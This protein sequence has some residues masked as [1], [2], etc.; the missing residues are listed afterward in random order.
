MKF[1]GYKKFVLTSLL[2]I[3]L[4]SSIMPMSFGLQP[5]KTISSA[6]VINY[7]QRVD[8][9]VNMS[10]VIGINNL[11]TG[12]Q[13]DFEWKT[14]RD[15]SVMRQLAK[16]A[17]FNIVRIHSIRIE[18]CKSW[19]ESTKTGTFSWTD[20]DNLM[21]KIFEIGAEP[22]IDLGYA[23]S[24][25]LISLPS[26]MATNPLT[27]LPY[28]DSWAAYCREWVKHFK[29]V[30]LPVRF[31]EIVN[32]PWMYFG[33]NNYTRLGY[34][35]DLFNAAAKAMRAENTK[36]LLGFDGTNRKPVL[37]YW[38]ANGGADL[39]FI[40]FH[41]YDS[42]A[43]GRYTD[44][45]MFV[46]AETVYMETDPWYYGIKDAQLVYKNA[47]G[48]VIPVINSESN[49]NSAYETGTDP[50]IQQ[51]IGAVWTALVLRTAILK[52]LKYNIYYCFCSSASWERANKASGGVG[53]G[54][55]NSDNN[56]PW[57]PYYVQWM[58]GRSLSVGDSI[59]DAKSSSSEIKVLALIH[60][61]RLNI[62]LICKVEQPRSIFL[63][64]ITGRLEMTKIDNDISWENPSLQTS[65]VNATDPITVKDYAVLLLRAKA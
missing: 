27:G 51:M 20:V 22:M 9:T 5:F 42:G 21:Q 31:Y 10:K 64:G 15:G 28:P 4:A 33:W 19:N 1:T 57:Y 25:G 49:F 30:D 17:N 65:E 50:K 16:D 3:I 11:S 6:G 32:E 46:R 14:W 45:E 53:F 54:M 41:K 37:D 43:I 13:L 36:V 2:E 56:K 44:A 52:G 58:I 39:D 12:F 26:G 7:W 34:F 29:N 24:E 61:G 63:N 60:E 62:F 18:P 35:K 55:V 38:L 40:S 59:V 8:V 48:K 47:R 23:N